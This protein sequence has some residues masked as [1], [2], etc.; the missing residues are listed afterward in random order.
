MKVAIVGYGVEG[1][2]SY[3]YFTRQGHEV[4]ICDLNADV[5]LPEM[6]PAQLGAGYLTDLD[7]FDVIVRSAGIPPETILATN[8]TVEPK[9]TTAVDEF[10]RVCPTRH[11]IGIT[12][13]K[14]KGTTCTLTARM[15]EAVGFRVFLGG[16]IGIPPLSFIDQISPDDYVVLELSSFQLTDLHYS[17]HTAAC[18]MVM[19]E[20][21]NWHKDMD[22]YILAKAQL[23]EHQVPEDTAIYYADNEDS[24]KIASYGQGFCIP[25]FADPGAY[26]DDG[27]VSIGNQRIC[28]VSDLKLLGTHNWQNVC[29]AVTIA[30]QFTQDITAIRSILTT[31]AGL[32]HRLEF[33]GEVDGVRYYDDSFGT[34]PET[35]VVAMQA[36]SEPKVVILGGSDKGA[37]YE[38]LAR[39]VSVNNVRAVIVIG[40]TAAA[41]TEAL[42]AIGYHTIIPGG[43]SMYEIVANARAHAGAGDVVLLSTGCASFGLFH[44]YKDRGDQFKQV[45]LELT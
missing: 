12:G 19:P 2:V 43:T 16:N 32:P 13:T 17:P 42:H 6:A 25:Y 41:I 44:D 29:A 5:V 28:S 21:L 39:A 36:F 10:L 18:L 8:P 14:G 30:W 34:T 31:F 1:R 4:T 37:S 40:D 35:A 20:H 33:V 27:F 24:R 15:L 7:R 11:T 45:V 23:F 22:D 26:I 38:E 3:D 9:I